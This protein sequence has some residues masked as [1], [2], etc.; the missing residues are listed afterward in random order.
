MLLVTQEKTFSLRRNSENNAKLESATF[1]SL[2]S[3]IL[4]II[5]VK[6]LLCGGGSKISVTQLPQGG[7]LW[8]N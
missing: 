6:G 8:G 1:I 2:F 4:Q 5:G 3:G 7:I